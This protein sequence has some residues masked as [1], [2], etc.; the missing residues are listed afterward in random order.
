MAKRNVPMKRT[1]KQTQTVITQ[2]AP[3]MDEHENSP[4]VIAWRLKAVEGK[5]QESFKEVNDKLDTALASFV[6]QA[7]FDEAKRQSA[8]DHRE[9][10]VEVNK[11]R[12]WKEG[13]INRIALGAVLFLVGV[14]LVLA[15]LN[16]YSVI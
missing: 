10:W 11:L 12:D 8:E 4:A 16:K 7:I 9:I 2:E 15:G 6:T 3:L 5:L 1:T 13:L 14:V